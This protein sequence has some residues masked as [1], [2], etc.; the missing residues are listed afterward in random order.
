MSNLYETFILLLKLLVFYFVAMLDLFALKIIWSVF[1][2]LICPFSCSSSRHI[3]YLGPLQTAL[4]WFTLPH[5]PHFLPYTGHF[6]DGWNGSVISPW[7]L[8]VSSSFLSSIP[9]MLVSS[10]PP[11]AVPK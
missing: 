2:I 3:A 10:G 7:T 5:S 8:L 1:T 11:L 4:I 6:W 9:L